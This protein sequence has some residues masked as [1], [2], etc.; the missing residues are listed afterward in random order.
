MVFIW[1]TSTHGVLNGSLLLYSS[2]ACCAIRDMLHFMC[3]K[4]TVRL[5]I[6]ELLSEMGVWREPSPVAPMTC[7]P[8]FSFH[9]PS[10]NHAVLDLPPSRPITG[11]RD[12]ASNFWI[13]G[14]LCLVLSHG[15]CLK[16]WV[17]LSF[18]WLSFDYSV[19]H[20]DKKTHYYISDASICLAW[21][22]PLCIILFHTV[23][24]FFLLLFCWLPVFCTVIVQMNMGEM[25]NL[26][27]FICFVPFLIMYIWN[28]FLFTMKLEWTARTCN[29][30][31][32]L[33]TVEWWF[34]D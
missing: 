8:G 19:H 2:M 16:W 14:V 29:N 20:Q 9:L 18:I 10:V 13:Q 31:S 12:K 4:H 32:S 22:N 17:K 27:S 11:G 5:W 26:F 21:C 28:S 25:H 3:Q 1:D 6:Y 30:C 34:Q 7:Y 24:F 33:V 23:G 15:D